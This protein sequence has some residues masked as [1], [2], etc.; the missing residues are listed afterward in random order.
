MRGTEFAKGG[1]LPISREPT[2]KIKSDASPRTG[3]YQ[4]RNIKRKRQGEKREGEARL[5]HEL[6]HVFV[7]K[8]NLPTSKASG[9]E[10]KKR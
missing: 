6:K 1:S 4:K 5:K 2:K 7:S 3:P 8:T 10:Q 9:M